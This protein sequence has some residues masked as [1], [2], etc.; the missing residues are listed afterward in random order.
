M[1]DTFGINFTCL[2]NNISFLNSDH[3]TVIRANKIGK[4]VQLKH[5]PNLSSKYALLNTD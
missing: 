1:P 4:Y 2:Q 5:F 3:N